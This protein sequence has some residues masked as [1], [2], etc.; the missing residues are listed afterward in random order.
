MAQVALITHSLGLR[1]YGIFALT[2]AV[3][4]LVDKFFDLDVGRASIVFSSPH[5]AQS[6]RMAAG[7][8]QFAYAL[9]VVT[10]MVGFAV[11][12]VSAPLIGPRLVGAHGVLLFMLYGMTLLAS[13]GDTT[14]SALLQALGRYWSIV[15]ITVFREVTRVAFVAFAVV[16]FH[17]LVV[18]VGLLL[19]HDALTG[20]IG[21]LIAAHAFGRQAKTVRLFQ[22]A[23][24]EAR[25]VRGPMLRM[26]FHTNLITYGRLVQAQAPTLL[27]G[28]FAGPLEVGLFK[29]AMAAATAIGQLTTPAWNAVMPRLSRLVAESG[30]P[31]VRQLLR[32]ST[33]LAAAL[34]VPVAS[35]VILFREPLLS[36]FGGSGAAQAGT[37]FVLVAIAQVVNGVLF[38]NGPYLY[39][40]HRAR[41]VTAIYLPSVALMLVLVFV[42]TRTSGADGA[43]VAVLVTAVLNNVLLTIA[44]LRALRDDGQ[45]CVAPSS[46]LAT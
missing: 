5:L 44:A 13:T 33:V 36:F 20:L 24:R 15:G 19:I 27:L 28:V 41:V 40:S 6:P 29:I 8:F 42:L 23:L 18:V 2:I 12:A 32:Q 17:S 46:L 9:N 26:I 21:I 38:W 45:R 16:A 11:I 22:P 3:V 1:Q 34:L 35:I 30:F 31:A 43:A 14:S 25:A 39:A 10:G 37:A 4:A 7:V